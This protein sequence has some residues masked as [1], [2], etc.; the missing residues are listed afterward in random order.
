MKLFLFLVVAL[1]AVIHCEAC[2]GHSVPPQIPQS[3][4]GTVIQGCTPR[5]ITAVSQIVPDPTKCNLPLAGNGCD[6][7]GLRLYKPEVAGT[8][9][10]QPIYNDLNTASSDHIK[11]TEC[12]CS[13][14]C[15]FHRSSITQF[16]IEPL[17]T[18]VN[19]VSGSFSEPFAC[20]SGI[21]MPGTATR[22]A[23]NTFLIWCENDG[24]CPNDV[25]A[26][27]SFL[28]RFELLSPNRPATT[29]NFVP[30][31]TTLPPTKCLL[32]RLSKNTQ[33]FLRGRSNRN[34]PR[35]VQTPKP[36]ALPSKNRDQCSPCNTNRQC[37][38]RICYQNTCI[39]KNSKSAKK[40]C[41]IASRAAPRP[42]DNCSASERVASCVR[43]CL[44]N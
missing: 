21:T 17:P 10:V 1:S 31:I 9:L 15:Y 33:D 30:K 39:R 12:K 8:F 34:G 6:L 24:G 42:V 35:S 38:S 27:F 11:A 37:K 28:I 20:F 19:G 26:R 40:T 32:D 36:P 29:S 23:N 7:C 13:D 25:V 3:F 41:G 43:S 5:V 44:N 2:A 16:G 22:S 4:I 18:N 14:G